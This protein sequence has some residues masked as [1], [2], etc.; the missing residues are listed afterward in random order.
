MSATIVI[1]ASVALKWVLPEPGRAA[2]LTILDRY[3]AG[4][5]SL[6]TPRLLLDEIASALARRCRQRYLTR[7]E[8]MQAYW[9][10]EHRLS[11]TVDW[12]IRSAALDLA[13][14]H[15]ISYWDSTYLAL[16]LEHRCDLMTADARLFRS[17]VR[18]YPFV[19][20]LESD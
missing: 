10:L 16:S 20:L 12:V 5:L 11:A 17:L 13:L 8:A 3:E 6:L 18:V 9:F 7:T 14:S 1:D 2:A 19:Q 15:Q 4:E